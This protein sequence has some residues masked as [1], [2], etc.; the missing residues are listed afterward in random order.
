M[1]PALPTLTVVAGL[2]PCRGNVLICQR[3]HDA[4]F[5]LKWEFPGGKIEPG[6]TLA[7]GLRRELR[8]ELGI[9]ADIGPEVYR[10]RHRYPDAYT[11]DLVFFYV[12]RFGGTVQNHAFEQIRWEAPSR[13]ATFDFLDGDAELI[14]LL[15]DGRLQVPPRDTPS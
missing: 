4:A 7:A 6:E 3:R 12:P 2:I 14:S 10:T 13:L 1:P 9:E 11:V 8:E 5:P 15:R